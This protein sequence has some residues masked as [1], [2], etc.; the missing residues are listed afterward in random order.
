MK[1][2]TRK[3]KNHIKSRKHYKNRRSN[4]KTKKSKG[5][6]NKTL[7]LLIG[8]AL[9]GTTTSFGPPQQ[10]FGVPPP[11][12]KPGKSLIATSL[13]S[14]P[15]GR[16]VVPINTSDAA[17]TSYKGVG[18]YI[19]NGAIEDIV[20]KYGEMLRGE[21]S[22]IDQAIDKIANE[23]RMK[24]IDIDD[25]NGFMERTN[26]DKRSVNSIANEINHDLFKG[27]S[28]EQ[29]VEQLATGF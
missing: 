2:I 12:K 10:K 1:N 29:S 28:L 19:K 7:A 23:E 3:R 14:P 4:R 21:K 20:H 6:I 16:G 9:V 25:I 17:V 22:D 13:E 26:V 18:E 11:P 15:I 8:L 24:N 5:G 27:M